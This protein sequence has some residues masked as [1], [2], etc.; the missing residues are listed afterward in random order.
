MQPLIN[1]CVLL[2][3]LLF[4]STVSER[5]HA[6]TL[7]GLNSDEQLELEIYRN[8]LP[9]LQEQLQV[10]KGKISRIQSN[11]MAKAYDRYVSN[12]YD[13][14]TRLRNYQVAAFEWQIFA[15][16]WV[17]ALVALLTISGIAF[18]GFQLWSAAR[19]ATLAANSVDLE[20]S[21]QKVRL[22]SSVVGI[23]LLVISGFFLLLFLNN[24]YKIQFIE[25]IVPAQVASPPK[26]EK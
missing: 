6:E 7:S 16:N 11:S 10:L 20:L 23:T 4:A 5:L 15:A 24:V 19:T 2:A 12:Y 26:S 9:E 14:E 22:Q 8:Y 18:A 3:F 17:L 21:T 25:G 13:Q 1:G